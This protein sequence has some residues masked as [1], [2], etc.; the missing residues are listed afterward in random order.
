MAE[1]IYEGATEMSICCYFIKDLFLY[2]C[3]NTGY[4]CCIFVFTLECPQCFANISYTIKMINDACENCQL[5][6]EKILTERY[7]M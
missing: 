3:S 1:I 6:C 2:I 4:I 5:H 7:M